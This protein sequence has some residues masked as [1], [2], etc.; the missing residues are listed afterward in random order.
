MSSLEVIGIIEGGIFSGLDFKICK[1]SSETERKGERGYEGE[2]HKC[3]P[4]STL[5]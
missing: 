3:V 1:G 4:H 2:Y 5:C